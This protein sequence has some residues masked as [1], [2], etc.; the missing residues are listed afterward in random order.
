[1]N[2]PPTIGRIVLAT[3]RDAKDA[4]VVRPAIIVRVWGEAPTAA[5]NVQVFCDGDGGHAND[6]LHNVVWKTSLGFAEEP[7]VLALTW[8]WP[9]RLSGSTS[10]PAK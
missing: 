6:G 3:I 10:A 2:T 9:P 1:M 7:G 4:L 8:S 5:V